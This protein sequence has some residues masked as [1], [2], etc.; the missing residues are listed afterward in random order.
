MHTCCWWQGP[1]E[2]LEARQELQA[3]VEAEASAQLAVKKAN[4]ATAAARKLLA[5]SKPAEAEA[6]KSA[7]ARLSQML[8]SQRLTLEATIA[9]SFALPTV[10]ASMVVTQ[11]FAFG[12]PVCQSSMLTDG[13]LSGQTPPISWSIPTKA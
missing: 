12:W 8:E 2:L 11:Y 1:C 9:F 4:A 13:L 3:A 6:R 5:E 7:E 10:D